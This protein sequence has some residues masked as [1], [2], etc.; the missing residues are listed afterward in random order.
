MSEKILTYE[1]DGEK[2]PNEREILN[3]FDA[4]IRGSY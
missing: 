4:L 3:Q 2:F 1:G